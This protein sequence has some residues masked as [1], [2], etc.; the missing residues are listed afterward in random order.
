MKI[1]QSTTWFIRFYSHA[2]LQLATVYKYMAGKRMDCVVYHGLYLTNWNTILNIISYVF[3][4]A[5]GIIRI[6]Q[7]NYVGRHFARK[8]VCFDENDINIMVS[9]ALSTTLNYLSLAI[10]LVY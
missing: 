7:E 2:T 3:N 6:M 1:Y 9:W 5:L 8:R 10:V 4:T